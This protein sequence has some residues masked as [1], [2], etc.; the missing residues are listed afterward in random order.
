MAM[1][2]PDDAAAALAQA[3][4]SRTQLAGGLGL[5]SCFH[6]SIGVTV[7]LQIAAA[8]VEVA[9]DTGWT[10]LLALA[11]AALFAATAGLQLSRFR[12]LNGVRIGGLTSRVALGTGWEAASS[13]AVALGGAFWAALSGRWWLVALCAGAGG[14]AYAYSG[15]RWLRRYRRAPA[16][17][18]QA[19]SAWWLVVLSALALVALALLALVGR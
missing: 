1:P 16:A 12:R 9:F 6:S 5:P 13:Y 4:T 15:Q 18:A 19:E 8:A 17:H 7:A 2:T 14:L 3:G 11:A 10:R